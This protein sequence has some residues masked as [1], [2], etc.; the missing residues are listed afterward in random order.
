M[1]KR[2]VVTLSAAALLAS[3]AGAQQIV[4]PD[5]AYLSATTKFT[6]P[7]QDLAVFTSLTEGSMT[8]TFSEVLTRLTVPDTWATWSSTPESEY[9][10]GDLIPVGYCEGCR[11]VRMSLSSAVGI[12]G[13]EAQSNSF[14]VFDFVANFYND[15]DLVGSVARSVDGTAGARL[16]AYE[17]AAGI[18]AVEFMIDGNSDFGM[19]AFRFGSASSVPE[20]AS[21]AMLG[22][23]LVGLVAVAR[24]RRV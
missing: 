19:A 5:V 15:G 20:P 24:R 17:S 22:F 11:S 18:N 23:G 10:P 16:F 21:A 14:S 6:L 8:L 9:A 4:N 1:L 2:F 3:T 12:F 13:F 7:A